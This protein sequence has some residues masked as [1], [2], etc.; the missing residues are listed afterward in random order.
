MGIF[1]AIF[2]FLKKLWNILRP[3]IAIALIAIAI[4]LTF[5]GALTFAAFSIGSL[6]FGAV[7]ISGTAAAL[8]AAGAAAW[9]SP[10]TVSKAINVVADAATEVL[11]AAA[12]V[13]TS[14]ITNNPLFGL[15]VGFGVYWLLTRDEPKT[16]PVLMGGER[17]VQVALDNEKEA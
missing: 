14:V 10:E 4:Y 13:A 17:P 3:L 9:L 6:S 16:V 2:G 5:G 1:K 15:A 7:T 11:S 12:G 8:I